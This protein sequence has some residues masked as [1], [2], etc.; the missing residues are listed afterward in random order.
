M[1]TIT[2]SR[3]PDAIWA[4][5]AYLAVWPDYYKSLSYICIQETL[6]K[7]TEHGTACNWSSYGSGRVRKL[8]YNDNGIV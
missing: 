2:P 6:S 7:S 8:E 1:I 5:C 3:I 4:P